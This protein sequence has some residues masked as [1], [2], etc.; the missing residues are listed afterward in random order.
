MSANGK[1]VVRRYFVDLMNDQRLDAVDEIM[2]QDCAFRAPVMPAEM[3]GADVFRQVVAGLHRTFPDLRFTLHDL[4]AEDDR[5]VG[6]W[7]MEGTHQGE[8]LGVAA[9]GR[10][11]SVT[12]I[13]TFRIRDGRIARIEIQADYLG[14]MR[15]M[16]ALDG[17]PPV[18]DS[19]A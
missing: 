19:A 17:P 10:R 12:G 3:R 6:S 1:D 16:G 7:T 13:D 15:Q 14:A 11:L 5:V 4:I 18:S 9:T 2:T 8:W